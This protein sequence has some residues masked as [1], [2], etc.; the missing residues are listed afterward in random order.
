MPSKENI[1]EQ[2]DIKDNHS[3][4]Q[5][6]AHYYSDFLGTDF[7]KGSIPKRRFQSKDKLGR[8]NGIS[9][10]KFPTFI[11]KV[12]KLINKDFAKNS[13]IIIKNN[14]HKANLP[15]I[16]VSAVNACIENLNFDNLQILNVTAINKFKKS[17][18]KL[19]CDLEIECSN[20]FDQL[21]RNVGLEIG[22]E[23]VR[24][25]QPTFARSGSNLIDTLISVENDIAELFVYPFE[26]ALPGALAELIGKNL[27]IKLLKLTEETFSE[28]TGKR[29]LRDFFDGFSSGDLFS[30][31]SELA[32]VEQLEDNLEYYLYLGE[33]KYNSHKF[34]LFYVPF[35]LKFDGVQVELS[36]EPRILINK[37]AIDYIARII[38]EETK[39]TSASVVENRII[40]VGPDDNI[41]ALIDDSTQAVLRAFQFEGE[42]TFTA[43]KQKIQNS[44]VTLDNTVSFA[45]FDKS[46]ESMLT[47]YEELLDKLGDGSGKLFGFLNDLID[48][49]LEENPL[50]IVEEVLDEWDETETPDRLVFDTPIPLAEEQRKILSALNNKHGK[51]I[52]VEGPPGTGKSHTISAIAFD[53]ILK[54]KS[55][56]ILSDKKEALDVVEN[57]LNET[58]GKVRP[59]D[60]FINPILRLGRVGSNFKK[61]TSNKS[62]ES[63]RLQNREI[64]K[65]EQ[66]RIKRYDLAV[67]KLKENIKTKTKKT[68]EIDTTLIFDLENEVSN[69]FESWVDFP[70]FEEIFLARE[71]EFEKELAAISYLLD[72]IYLCREFDPKFIEF[73]LHLGDDAEA[74]SRAITLFNLIQKGANKTKLFQDAP[75]IDFEKVQTLKEK[76]NELRSSKGILGYLFAG[77]KIVQIKDDLFDLVGFEI[78]SNN[79]SIVVESIEKLIKKA[80]D[81]YVPLIDG[82]DDE[83]HLIPDV[84]DIDNTDDY[85]SKMSDSL[86]YLHN[87]IEKNKIPFLGDDEAVITVLTEAESRE[88]DFFE[89]FQRLRQ[90]SREIEHKFELNSYSYLL[91][92]K[93]IEN[94]NA[95]KLATEID[96]RVIDFADKH[97][98]DA[99]TLSQI[100]QQ[101]KK[102]PKDKFNILKSAFPCMICS[103]RDYAE[104]IPLEEELFDIVIIDEASQVSIAQAFP[105]IIRAKKM[106][107]L[108]DRKQF[109]NVKTSNAS[110]ELNNAYFAKVKDALLGD[111]NYIDTELEVKTD[112]LNIRNS[113]LD[114]MEGISNFSIMLKKHFRGYPEMISFS[115]KYFYSNGLQAMKLRGKNIEDVLEFY[116]VENDGKFDVYKNTN[117][118]E[119]KAILN[120]VLEQLGKSDFSS[121]A[122]ITPFKDQQAYISKIFSEHELYPEILS[123]LKFRCFTFDSCQGEERDYIFY[124]FVASPNIDKLW[125]V[126]PVQ[127]NQHDEESLDRNLR[128]QR[129]NVA[130]SRGKEKLIFVHSK[131]ISEFSAGREVL[132]HY[133]QVIAK[134]KAVPNASTVD[135]N[136]EAEKKVLKWIQQTPIYLE[137]QPEII[138][139][140]DI[141]DYLKRLDSKYNHPSYRVDFLLR[142]NINEKQRDIILEYDGFEFHFTN[143][144]EIDAGNWKYYLT[145]KDV[146]REHVLEGY[147]YKMLRINKFNVGDDPIQ[148]LS[149]RISEILNDFE[150][151][152]ASLIQE[153]LND[154]AAAH[155]GFKTGAY[156]H[157]KKCDQNRPSQEFSDKAMKSGFRRFCKTCTVPKAKMKSKRA[158]QRHSIKQKKKCPNCLNSFPLSE[159]VDNSNKSG[160]RSLCGN[161]KAISNRKRQ[162]NYRAYIN[163]SG[164]W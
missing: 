6:L 108:G 161:C 20:L 149:D 118:L 80:T 23:I 159:F 53:A 101:K 144:D 124:S 52:T 2:I 21:R 98:N 76:I 45:L 84:L 18:K 153:V 48:S 71:D 105:A 4:V 24:I 143:R 63:L 62:I 147:G 114:F 126:L 93:E 99:R 56:L 29:M 112:L 11:T 44:F 74:L 95:L 66:K 130:F 1:E 110:K 127:L 35:K 109:G 156:R 162:E 49:F 146:E 160:K 148:T 154:T 102:F 38:R 41:T 94:Y 34:P 64:R 3:F 141:G 58:L 107:V 79:G 77:K 81:F 30:E 150:D 88:A 31:I 40:Y 17:I 120:R 131:P 26:E 145:E 27:D 123:K 8:R 121:V 117:H 164:R 134:A 54:G 42:L 69:F 103:L 28:A 138:P 152:G 32:S 37:K 91:E 111:K 119:A 142:F 89:T 132:S 51:F 67:L 33:I 60:E 75:E 85:S 137:F 125:T 9:L 139:Q 47:D 115:S 43:K 25:L 10:D 135:P 73:A 136:S 39:T 57:K 122:V 96:R 78:A 128:M 116:P 157:C 13:S 163:R 50:T 14:D 65:D 113:I 104:Y 12:S 83:L 82:F 106:I 72:Q 7:K 140:F 158:P 59:S 70:D 155:E 87:L 61:I 92:K 19:D 36:L 151:T 5:R 68:S 55:I 22:V 129:L 15:I 97:K 90:T 133:A 100:I 86:M 46:D 16:L